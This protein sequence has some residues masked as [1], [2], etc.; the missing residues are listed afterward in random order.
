MLEN[1]RMLHWPP[2]MLCGQSSLGEHAPPCQ[3]PPPPQYRGDCSMHDDV[4]GLRLPARAAAELLW[5]S[6]SWTAR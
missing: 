2:R 5:W 6:A 1:G 3:I 4:G